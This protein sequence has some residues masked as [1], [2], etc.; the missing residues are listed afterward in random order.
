M[1]K[2]IKI[3][4]ELQAFWQVILQERK[5]IER[6]NKSIDFWKTELVGKKKTRTDIQSRIMELK[7]RQKTGELELHVS[8]EKIKKLEHKKTI[9]QTQKEF[10][11]VDNEITTVRAEKNALED[12]IIVLMDLIDT[13]EKTLA[14]IDAELPAMEK[15][16]GNDIEMLKSDIDKSEEI[17]KLNQAHFDALIKDLNPALQGKFS[18]LLNSKNGIAIAEVSGDVCTGCNFVIPAALTLDATKSDKTINCTNCGR[19]IYK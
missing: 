14:S 13:E 3:M 18:K 2:D 7:N 6:F 12:S 11:A 1:N 17:I 19:Y 10:S 16:V 8:E 4:I 9:I 5:N 15:Q